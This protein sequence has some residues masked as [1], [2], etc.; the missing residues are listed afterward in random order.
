MTEVEVLR[1]PSYEGRKILVD[2]IWM[3]AY[4]TVVSIGLGDQI[5]SEYADSIT[6]SMAENFDE[7][8]A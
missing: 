2:A 5:A 8:A 1:A 6:K 3:A 4:I 7:V